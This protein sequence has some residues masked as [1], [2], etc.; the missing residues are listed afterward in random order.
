MPEIVHECGARLKFAPGMEGRKG[1]CPTCG[2]AVVVPGTRAPGAPSGATPMLAKSSPEATGGRHALWTGD[3]SVTLEPP[4]NWTVYE[5][6]LEG[7]TPPPREAVIPAT[8]MLKDEAD[9]K[10]EAGLA[11]P[12][13]S[14]FH[15][16]GCKTRLDVGVL[17]CTGC[18]LDLRTGRNV[19]GKTKVTPEGEAYLAKIPWVSEA[20]EKAKAGEEAGEAEKDEGEAKDKSEGGKRKPRFGKLGKR[21]GR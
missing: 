7:K 10:W 13:P 1:R 11:K 2:L 5:A 9:A 8:I 16:P 15:C 3:T 19:D 20:R 6:F 17:V 14:K 12:P 4:P 21:P 18:G